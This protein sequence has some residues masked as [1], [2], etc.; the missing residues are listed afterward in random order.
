MFEYKS[1]AL[2]FQSQAQ[3]NKGL[4]KLFLT[5]GA[6]V[7]LDTGYIDE[8]VNEQA[9]DGWELVTYSPLLTPEHITFIVTF[10]KAK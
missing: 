2:S 9:A 5:E 8:L 6:A 7:A 3:P 1:M 10:K 4:K